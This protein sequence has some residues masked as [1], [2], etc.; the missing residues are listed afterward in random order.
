MASCGIGKKRWW[1]PSMSVTLGTL[2]SR[3]MQLPQPEGR[4]RFQV[5]RDNAVLTDSIRCFAHAQLRCESKW[6]CP[7]MAS[8]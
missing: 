2:L 6:P 1:S 5:L 3:A 4:G 8:S 7:S